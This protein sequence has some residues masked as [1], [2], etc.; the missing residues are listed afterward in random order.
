M[1]LTYEEM[2]TLVDNVIDKIRI[3]LFDQNREGKIS[4]Y[5]TNIGCSE[6]LK[7]QTKYN[8]SFKTG[9]IV[10]IGNVSTKQKDLIGIAKSLGISKERLEFVDYQES[11]RYQLSKLQYQSKYRVILVG[12]MPHSTNGKENCSSAIAN[13]EKQDGYPRVIRLENGN[14]LKITKT[15]FK[16]QLERLIKEDYIVIG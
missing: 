9:I 14:E 3:M 2:N 8:E 1:V 6:F 4:Q 12:P 16:L 10:V 5:L 11:V 13:M 15:N 7:Q